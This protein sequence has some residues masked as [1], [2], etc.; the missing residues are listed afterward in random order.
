MARTFIK[1]I[2]KSRLMRTRKTYKPK[3][4][5]IV[6]RPITSQIH[7]FKRTQAL[8]G[9][10]IQTGT[11]SYNTLTFNLDSVVNPTDFTNLFSQY[12][13]TGIKL[14]FIPTTVQQPLSSG[15][16]YH[17]INHNNTATPA[18]AAAAMEKS[19]CRVTPLTK[20]WSLFIKPNTLEDGEVIYRKWLTISESNETH[21]GWSYYV[22]A[23]TTAFTI[24]IYATYYFQCKGTQ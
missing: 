1:R 24:S 19:N 20:R 15:N 6:S 13:I 7:N 17:F 22:D 5:L 23:A 9:I 18:S 8:T 21:Y 4:K 2:K 3:K 12:R 10:S 14:Q 16:M 11:A